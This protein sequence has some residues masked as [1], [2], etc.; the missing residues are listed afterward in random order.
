[1][2][3]QIDDNLESQKSKGIKFFMVLVMEFVRAS[4]PSVITVPPVSFQFIY[5]IG[6]FQRNGSGW[7]V[8][9][10]IQ[11]DTTILEFDPLRAS[12]FI[13]LYPMNWGTKKLL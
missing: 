9:D 3:N 5:N 1:M 8:K 4:N 2:Q 13:N 10:I 12:S 11:L 6:E 7:I